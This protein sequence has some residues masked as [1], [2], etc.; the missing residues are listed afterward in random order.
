MIRRAKP[1]GRDRETV[2]QGR[3]RSCSHSHTFRGGWERSFSI[4]YRPS[5]SS[6]INRRGV[7]CRSSFATK[8]AADTHKIRDC[9]GD[10]LHSQRAQAEPQSPGQCR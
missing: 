1:D 4:R 7:R 10:Y 5:P 8:G 9:G 6:R 3:W 2:R